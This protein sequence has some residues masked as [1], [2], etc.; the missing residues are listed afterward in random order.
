MSLFN[1]FT[2]IKKPTAKTTQNKPVRKK[3][4]WEREQPTNFEFDSIDDT[5]L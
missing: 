2:R 3:E 4:S 5:D 1:I